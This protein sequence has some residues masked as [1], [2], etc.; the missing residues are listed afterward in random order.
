MLL[1][2]KTIKEEIEQG[3]LVIDPYDERLVQPVSV[4]LH[5]GTEFLVFLSGAT[6]PIIEPTGMSVDNAVH[7]QRLI[8]NRERPCF[9]LYPESP[10]LASTL[11]KF[12]LPNDIV[13]H[14]YG[15]SSLGRI[16]LMVSISSGLVAP[17]Y[18][19]SLTL[20][21]LNF[22]N[23]PIK[24]DPGMLIA[25]ISF[26]RTD[27]P[28]ERPYGANGLGSHY[29]GSNGTVPADFRRLSKK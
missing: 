19:G 24:L 20:E 26:E 16:G 1:S 18:E 8:C 27:V 23:R 28:V 29:I 5:L 25:Q 10:V 4:D 21:L 13:G 7:Y 15:K 3:R 12:Q 9:Y 22:T 11:E 14:L 2:D 17:G 6:K